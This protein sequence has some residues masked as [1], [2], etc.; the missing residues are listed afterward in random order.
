VF[1]ILFMHF[2]VWWIHESFPSFFFS[3]FFAFMDFCLETAWWCSC[4]ARRCMGCDEKLWV[5]PEAAEWD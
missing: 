4:P 1:E 5:F 2:V 3:L